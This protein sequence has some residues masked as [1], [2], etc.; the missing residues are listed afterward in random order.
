MKRIQNARTD[1]SI[2][3]NLIRLWIYRKVID[4]SNHIN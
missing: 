1:K 2:N 4:N 3:T